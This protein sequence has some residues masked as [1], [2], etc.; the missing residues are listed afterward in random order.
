VEG[1][2]GARGGTMRKMKIYKL[3]S[4]CFRRYFLLSFAF[5]RASWSVGLAHLSI[6]VLRFLC[7]DSILS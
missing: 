7:Y 1:R 2:P 4:E 6:S 3:F 5:G